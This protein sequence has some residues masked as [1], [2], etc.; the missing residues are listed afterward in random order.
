MYWHALKRS[1]ERGQ[2][3]FDFGRSTPESGTY[4]FKE[5]WGAE[6]YPAV[7][8]YVMRRG[9]P[10]DVRPNSGKFDRVIQIWQKLPVW[11]TRLIGPSIVRGIP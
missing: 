8:Q 2:Q 10:Q 3:A 7:W 6:A 9:T 11:L 5:Q 4:R 1:V